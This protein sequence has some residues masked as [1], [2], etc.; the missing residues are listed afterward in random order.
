MLKN[1]NPLNNNGLR[2]K[3][4]TNKKKH[5]IFY[6][7]HLISYEKINIFNLISALKLFKPIFYNNFLRIVPK[8]CFFIQK[9]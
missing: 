9:I 1:R 4:F 2:Q 3:L 6:V 8:R 7:F 5:L